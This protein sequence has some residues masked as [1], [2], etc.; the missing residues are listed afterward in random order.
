MKEVIA[1][2]LV[3]AKNTMNI[4]RGCTHGC[5]YC[6]S[7][8]EIYGKTFDFENIEVKI[9]A[10]ELLK[11]ELGK[12]RKKSMIVTGSMTDPYIP[13]E[14]DLQIMRQCLEVIEKQGFGAA[15][16]TKSDLILR[17]V[18]VL[19]RI[20][21]KTKAVVQMTLTT[22]DE[23]L[24]KILEPHVCG[25][26]RRAEVL[27]EM[28]KANIPTIVWFSPLLPFINDTEENVRGILAYC[29]EAG[30]KGIIT[31]GMG[32]TLRSGNRQYYYQEIE[33]HWPGLKQKYMRAFGS[34]Y[35]LKSPQNAKL[36]RIVREFCKKNNM[37][38]GEKEV[39]SYVW[40]F[41]QQNEQLSFGDELF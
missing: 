19:K 27:A 21:E 34:S 11:K 26:R 23:D 5:I 9:N 38:Y 24:C 10:V 22:F 25:T 12:K 20:N 16:L 3:S 7:R 13:L 39:F 32:M 36:S 2:S 31:F 15:V 6:D 17:D 33:K 14:R 28:H 29:K 35:G 41:P 18:D 4:Y 1:K 40:D 8:S 30:V 37:L